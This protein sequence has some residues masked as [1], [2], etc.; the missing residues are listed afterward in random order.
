MPT[1]NQKLYHYTMCGLD[2]IY[3]VNGYE[4]HQ[5]PDGEGISIHNA[6]ELHKLIS[7]NII[8][9]LPVLTGKEIRFLRS[10]MKMSQ[11]TLGTLL[12]VDEQTVARWE[13]GKFDVHPAADRMIRTFYRDFIGEKEDA[14]KLC[15]LLATLQDLDVRQQ[16]MLEETNKGWE[17]RRVG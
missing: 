5:T 13:K 3:L 12:G 2:Y 8:D 16:V 1:S 10:R 6:E 15:E 9:H 17:I 4:V 11:F 14:L 7:L